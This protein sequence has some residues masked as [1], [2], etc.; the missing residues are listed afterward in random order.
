LWRVPLRIPARLHQHGPSFV[1]NGVHGFGLS[2]RDDVFGKCLRLCCTLY[3]LRQAGSSKP[4]FSPV[5][6]E[7]ADR[8]S[9][10]SSS[11]STGISLVRAGE[12]MTWFTCTPYG[13]W[14]AASIASTCGGSTGC[15]GAVMVPSVRTP[16]VGSC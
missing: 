7:R 13:S 1:G 4:K 9:G 10:F 6:S 11:F 5:S 16:G 2:F 8:T 12:V 14:P 3:H 15:P